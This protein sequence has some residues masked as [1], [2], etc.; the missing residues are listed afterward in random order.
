[1]SGD[2]SGKKCKTERSVTECFCDTDL[3]NKDEKAVNS[4]TSFNISGLLVM[5][6]VL[7]KNAF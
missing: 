6:V 3:C 5:A 1:M 7:A 2:K 4:S